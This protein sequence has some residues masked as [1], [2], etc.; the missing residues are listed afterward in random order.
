MQGK[1]IDRLKDDEL[2]KV[3]GGTGAAS[4]TGEKAC[5]RCGGERTRKGGGIVCTK[6]G[7]T[8]VLKMCPTC[9]CQRE[10]DEFSGGRYVCTVCR[11][12]I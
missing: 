5:P 2:L 1:N 10:C 11:N 12:R 3:S 9:G 4:G 6:C 7:Y 8:V